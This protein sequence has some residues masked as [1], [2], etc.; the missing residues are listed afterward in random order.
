MAKGPRTCQGVTLYTEKDR[1][2][3]REDYLSTLK[4]ERVSISVTSA[5]RQ[6]CGYSEKHFW[7]ALRRF[8]GSG[9]VLESL[10]QKGG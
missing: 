4:E 9:V 7:R 1:K 3:I 6:T 2:I 5:D 10:F 8:G